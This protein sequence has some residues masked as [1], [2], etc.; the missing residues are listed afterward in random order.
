VSGITVFQ[1][2]AGVRIAAVELQGLQIWDAETGEPSLTR[3]L[4]PKRLPSPYMRHLEIPYVGISPGAEFVAVVLPLAPGLAPPELYTLTI[5]RAVSGKTVEEIGALGWPIYS[6]SVQG[7]MAVESFYLGSSVI[8]LETGKEIYRF[9][10][11]NFLT[12]LSFSPDR[13]WV[14]SGHDDG[15]VCIWD[16]RRP[17]D[18]QRRR[19]KRRARR[20]KPSAGLGWRGRSVR[21]LKVHRLCHRRNARRPQS[22]KLT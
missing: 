11:P 21:H 19:L 1:S 8:N 17:Q 14:A 4:D 3:T 12:S 22:T 5:E 7:N 10:Y 2:P 18:P 6:F 9:T 16:T 15:R 20:H 13:R